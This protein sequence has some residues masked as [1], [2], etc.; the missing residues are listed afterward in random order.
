MSRLK[1]N[2]NGC[3]QTVSTKNLQ[4]LVNAEQKAV[5]MKEK[6]PE[7]KVEIVTA[8]KELVDSLIEKDTHNR[9]KKERHIVYLKE[10]IEKG[11][12]R[13][14]NQGIGVTTEGWLCD[15]GHRLQAIKR[16]GYPPVK[17]LLVTG[18]APDA[19]AY[20]DTHNKRSMADVLTLLTNTAVSARAVATANVLLKIE[21]KGDT[22]KFSPED[23]AAKLTEIS[24]YL[25][26]IFDINGHKV[27]SAGVVAGIISVWMATNSSKCIDFTAKLIVGEMLK[28]D[29]PAFA[30]RMHL[31]SHD[32]ITGSCAQMD[33][34]WRTVNSA[35]SHVIGKPQLRTSAAVVDLEKVSETFNSSNY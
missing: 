35:L 27:L 9:S 17:F 18:L 31:L 30:L 15:G 26:E 5:S 33:R 6:N 32:A 29:E 19:Q 8:T 28:R 24:S 1:I 11:N 25:K 7:V 12:W 10:E 23:T 22:R 13:L 14:T 4:H 3:K 34:Y 16:A 20:V 2:V 21:C